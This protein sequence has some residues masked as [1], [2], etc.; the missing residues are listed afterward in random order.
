VADSGRGTQGSEAR[1]G[2]SQPSRDDDGVRLGEARPSDGSPG[3]LPGWLEGHRFED[4]SREGYKSRSLPIVRDLGTKTLA[5]IE[6]AD[7]RAFFRELEKGKLAASTIRHTRTVLNE[8]FK[9]AVI[10]GLIDRNPCEG[11]KVKPES[12]KEMMI[13]TPA[14]AKMIR[15]AIPAPYKLLVEAMFATGMRYSELMGLRPQDI[16][17][18][19]DVAVIKAGRSVMVEVAGKPIYKD[20]GKTKNAGRDIRVSLTS[21]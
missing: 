11:V 19:G 4:S 20:Y 12:N 18:S 2:T 7:V 21:A 1:R 16:E 15:A 17:I 13:A 5:E 14:Q 3:Y 9:C 6:P 8:M 10:D